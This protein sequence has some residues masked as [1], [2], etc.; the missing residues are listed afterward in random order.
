[1]CVPAKERERD[2]QTVRTRVPKKG[3]ETQMHAIANRRRSLRKIGR[4]ASEKRT[5]RID[6]LAVIVSVAILS[7]LSQL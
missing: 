5:D 1:M 3:H 7:R 2:K 4:A 6:M